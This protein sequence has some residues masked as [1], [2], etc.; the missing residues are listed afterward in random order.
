M[1]EEEENVERGGRGR[2]E[3]LGCVNEWQVMMCTSGRMTDS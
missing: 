3:V 1:Y 2:V